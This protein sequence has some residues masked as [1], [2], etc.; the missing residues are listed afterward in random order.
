MLAYAARDA[1]GVARLY[2]RPLDRFEASVVPE[3]EGAQAP[4]FS[5]DGRRVGFFTRAKL[6]TAAVAGGAPTPIADASSHP[7]GGTWGE[8]DTIVFGPALSLGLRRV[9]SSG[10]T[11]QQLTEPDEAARGYAHGRPQFLPGGRSLLFT[12]WGTS[13]AEDRGPALLSLDKGTWTHIASGIWSA[14]YARSGHLLLSGPRGVRAAPFDPDHPR[15]TNPQTFV[16]DEVFSTMAWSDSWFAVSDTGT[17][18]YVP[19]DATLGRLAWVERDGRV[20]PV[21]DSVVSLSDPSLSPDGERIAFQ[22]RDDNLWTLD[23]RRGTRI[24][25][26]LDGEGSNAYPAW[27]RDGSHVL[28]VEPERRLGDHLHPRGGRRRDAGP[29]AE[30]ESV[31]PSCAPDGTLLFDERTKAKTRGR[32][33]GSLARRHGDALSR[34]RVEHGGRPVLA[35]RPR[36]R[37]R[38]GRDRARRGVRAPV[39]RE[40]RR[41]TRL[42]RRWQL[43]A[44]V[45]RRTRGLLPAG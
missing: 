7:L 14:H 2:L 36:S 32:S 1:T 39:R 28:F 13:S 26:T 5:P 43:T 29:H 24:R 34:H 10:G 37:V 16:V 42:H 35:G 31:S 11:L 22:D 45:A 19:G 8:D 30:G 9:P 18:A 21:S 44:L 33:A 12:I 41:R 20:S 6:L 40:R 17:L 4:F 25:L 38:L 3:S 27:S 15:P 23:L